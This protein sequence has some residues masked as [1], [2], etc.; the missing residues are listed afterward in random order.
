MAGVLLFHKVT[1][2][3]LIHHFGREMSKKVKKKVTF[4]SFFEMEGLKVGI[5]CHFLCTYFVYLF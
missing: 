3:S 1:Y 5:I 4:L 2:S